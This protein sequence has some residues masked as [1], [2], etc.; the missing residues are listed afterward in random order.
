MKFFYVMVLL[1]R[2]SLEVPALPA[3]AANGREDITAVSRK[4]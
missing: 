2:I 1:N 3:P 4:I